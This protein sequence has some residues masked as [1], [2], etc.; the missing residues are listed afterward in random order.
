MDYLMWFYYIDF[1]SEKT[2]SLKSIPKMKE[3]AA[4]DGKDA[5]EDLISTEEYSLEDLM[6]D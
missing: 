1:N 6:A 2:A 5:P 3:V 4:W